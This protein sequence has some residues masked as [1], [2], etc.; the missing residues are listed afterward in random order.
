MTRDAAARHRRNEIERELAQHGGIAPVSVLIA[1]GHSRHV[2]DRL[3]A[4][5]ALVRLRRGWV[6]LA[7]SDPQLAAA[8]RHGVVLTCATAAERLGLFVLAPPSQPHV[9]APPTKG[10]AGGLAAH[11]HWARPVVPRHPHGLVDVVE[12]VLCLAAACLP[13]EEALAVWESAL[14][15]R[16]VDR[17]ALET[18][19][20]PPAARALLREAD[21]FADS[22]LETLVMPRLRWL[23]LPLRR[24]IWISG[25]RVDLL[26]GDRLVIQIDGA[27]HTGAQRSSDIAHDAELMLLGYH[28]M[29]VGYEQIVHR[30]HEVQ[31]RIMRAIAQGLHLER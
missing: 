18:L 4:E 6:G 19:A 3:C 15:R 5:G 20:L 28:V 7:A 8:A 31:E 21:P 17:K 11:V 1:R 2:I 25:H 14:R 23:G 24:Q 16:L 29:R 10:R 12:N 30:W 9:A 27:T 26:I 13:H 22:G